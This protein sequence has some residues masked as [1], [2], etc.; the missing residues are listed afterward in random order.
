MRKDKQTALKLRLN[1]LSYSEI[2][3]VLGVP[4]STL[5]GW[6]SNLVISKERRERIEKRTRKKSI[7]ALI[8]HNKE[9]A[10]LAIKRAS[11]I[12][13]QAGEELVMLVKNDLLILG[14]AL[15]WAEGYKRPI[16]RNNREVTHHVV[17][18]TNSDP[19][20][21][22]VFL[23]FLR[24][25][26]QVPE[27]KIKASIRIYEHQNESLLLNY[28]QKETQIPMQNFKKTYYGV[29]KSSLGRRPFNRLL[30]GTIQV[31][32]ADTRLFHRIMGYIEKMKK[33]V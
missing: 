23:K 10:K 30:Y 21:I 13:K 6:F 1:G 9:Q 18:M 25:Y 15:Y 3:R 8:K 24:D 7:L 14:S 28:W 22:K 27:E 12:R 20:L 4:K 5:S 32:V 33:L 19:F 17:S 2:N 31:V 29:S 16:I 11:D 26:C